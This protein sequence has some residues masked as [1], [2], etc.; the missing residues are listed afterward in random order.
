MSEKIGQQSSNV[1][2][3]TCDDFEGRERDGHMVSTTKVM[4]Q[5]AVATARSTGVKPKT[6]GLIPE[7]GQKGS[8]YIKKEVA[9][10]RRE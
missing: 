9:T 3:N 2:K 4:L 7:D 5:K 8:L 6:M 10:D 1:R